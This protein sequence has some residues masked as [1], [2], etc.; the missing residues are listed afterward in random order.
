MHLLRSARSADRQVNFPCGVRRNSAERGISRAGALDRNGVLL[1]QLLNVAVNHQLRHIPLFLGVIHVSPPR[2]TGFI[3][4]A[5]RFTPIGRFHF[6]IV[7]SE[8]IEA[9]KLL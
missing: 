6:H 7:Q 9:N 4:E 5:D 3:I 8:N 2:V 1:R